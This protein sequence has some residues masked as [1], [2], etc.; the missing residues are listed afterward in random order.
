[1][2]L[3]DATSQRSRTVLIAAAPCS[4]GA[5]EETIGIDA[6]TPEAVT[7]L[8]EAASAGYAG[9]DLGPVGY[10][11]TGAELTERLSARNLAL[12]GGFLALRF[13]QP[14]LLA[15]ALPALHALLDVFDE[16]RSEGPPP[17]PTLAGVGSPTA[18]L[19]SPAE[20]ETRT[21][22]QWARYADGVARAAHTCRERG[23]EPTFHHHLGS[24]I[25]TTAEIDRLLSLTD[26]GLCLDTG[27][28]AVAG[29]DPIDALRRWRERVNHIHI[30]DASVPTFERML[31]QGAA[32]DDLWRGE[33]F[34]ALG[35]G[36]LRCD[37]FLSELRG[38]GY[39]GWIVVEQDVYP[40]RGEAAR[41]A[42][43]EQ[44]RSRDYL[45]RRGY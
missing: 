20:R 16:T 26:V 40:G 2:A 34:V 43:A 19:R 41:Q 29:G 38:I 31:S 36:G 39:S 25:E 42:A 22:A 10:L 8:D 45:K 23:F 12:A 7:V 32:V 6:A 33:V 18:R 35:E 24:P 17:R 27:H 11:G 44:R 30:K 37:E 9:I 4:Y 3:T 1:M 21:A 13:D 28:L 5:F 14:T 15:E